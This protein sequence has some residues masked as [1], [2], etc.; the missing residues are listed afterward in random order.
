MCCGVV[1]GC[2]VFGVL[3]VVEDEDEDLLFLFSN[4]VELLLCCCC[5]IYA[6]RLGFRALS[7]I[8]AGVSFF[9]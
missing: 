7:I 3:Y 4:V 9:L 1:G 5:F 6:A 2:G 8:I